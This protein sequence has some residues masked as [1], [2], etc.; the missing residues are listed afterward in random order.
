[1]IGL[2]GLARTGKDTMCN[3]MLQILS[4]H[5]IR[6]KR[7][8]IADEIKRQLALILGQFYIDINVFD[9]SD[10]DKSLIRPLMVEWGLI[11]RKRTQGQYLTSLL[12]KEIDSWVSLD[13]SKISVPI[14]TDIRYDQYEKDEVFWLKDLN[15][16]K[17][18]HIKK[19]IAEDELGE[20]VFIL[21]PNEQEALN[22]PILQLKSDYHV[23]WDKMEGSGHT[24]EYKN[25]YY[26][27]VASQVLKKLDII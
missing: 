6:G 24:E 11:H 2:C 15:K 4:E 8:S 27:S 17:L 13:T 7:F 20:P 12:Q 22:D 21:P 23:E 16:G 14:V 18:V 5:G 10:E 25:S 26:Y 19:K 1:M 9:C 3:Y